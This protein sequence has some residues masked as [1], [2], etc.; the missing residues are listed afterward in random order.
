MIVFLLGLARVDGL[1]L[2]HLERGRRAFAAAFPS[3]APA[4]T[5]PAAWRRSGRGLGSQYGG[6]DYYAGARKIGPSLSHGE[7]LPFC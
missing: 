5:A 2:Y 4:D 7:S 1:A 6:K 3:A